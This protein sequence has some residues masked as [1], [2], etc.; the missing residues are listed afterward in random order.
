MSTILKRCMLVN[1]LSKKKAKRLLSFEAKLS[2]KEENKLEW[3][4]IKDA[5]I[6]EW[7]QFSDLKL[8]SIE[9]DT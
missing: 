2:R 3:I 6:K 1:N 8:D 7:S 9:S 4:T 5:G